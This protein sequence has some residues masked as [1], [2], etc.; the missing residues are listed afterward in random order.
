MA[1]RTESEPHTGNDTGTVTAPPPPRTRGHPGWTL[2]AKTIPSSPA[3]APHP[4][5]P[6]SRVED[7]S[8]GHL[9]ATVAPSS[10]AQPDL[11]DQST[12][13]A[14]VFTRPDALGADARD[15]DLHGPSLV[16]GLVSGSCCLL[17]CCVAWL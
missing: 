2:R 6:C 7:P 14:A 16:V 17:S 12:V 15:L 9:A 8:V 13:S 3:S 11:Q 10:L 1:R 5:R 4:E